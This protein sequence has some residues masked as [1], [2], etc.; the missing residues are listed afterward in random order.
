[1][2]KFKLLRIVLVIV[3]L[4]CAVLPAICE[5]AGDG[6]E[7]IETAENEINLF[8]VKQ[9]DFVI[10]SRGTHAYQDPYASAKAYG[11]FL[12]RSVVQ[13]MSIETDVNGETWYEVEYLSN[14][15]LESKE[16]YGGEAEDKDEPRIVYVRASE[17]YQRS[18][19]DERKIG[20]NV[21]VPEG[22]KPLCSP[23]A[24]FFHENL[25]LSNSVSAVESYKYRFDEEYAVSFTKRN[26]TVGTDVS[27]DDILLTQIGSSATDDGTQGKYHGDSK[28]IYAPKFEVQSGNDSALAYPLGHFYAKDIPFEDTILYKRIKMPNWSSGVQRGVAFILSHAPVFESYISWPGNYEEAS[29]TAAIHAL[30]AFLNDYAGYE[31][32]ED[33]FTGVEAYNNS[34]FNADYFGYMYW[35]YNGAARA[36]SD[37]ECKLE[38]E[39]IF[40]EAENSNYPKLVVLSEKA[41]SRDNTNQIEIGVEKAETHK[42]VAEQN[43]VGKIEIKV[44]D[45]ENGKALEGASYR[46]ERI[47]N[48]SKYEKDAKSG[49]NGVVAFSDVPSGIYYLCQNKSPKGYGGEGLNQII[50]IKPDDKLSYQIELS[51]LSGALKV[52][53]NDTLYNEPLSNVEFDININK[54]NILA[55]GKTDNKGE[56][57]IE[58]IPAG[59]YTIRAKSKEGY[60][61]NDKSYTIKINVGEI[62]IQEI[63]FEPVTTKM[64]IYTRDQEKVSVDR[65]RVSAPEAQG[66][67]KLEKAKFNLFAEE[68]ILTPNGNV[69]YESG[70]CV[71]EGIEPSGKSLMFEMTGLIPGKYR[72]VETS[73]PEGYYKAEDIIIDTTSAAKLIANNEEIIIAKH[74]V[75]SGKISLI[76]YK[77]AVVNGKGET[78]ESGA[79]FEI[80]LTSSGSYRKAPGEVC[81]RIITGKDGTGT[82]KSMPYGKYTITQTSGDKKTAL[83][84]PFEVL[85]DGSDTNGTPVIVIENDTP[86]YR[87]TIE[88]VDTDTK[89]R[90]PIEGSQ[91]IVKKN[92]GTKRILG[93]INKDGQLTVKEMLVPGKYTIEQSK[94]VE[95]YNPVKS[96]VSFELGSEN[97]ENGFV[98]QKTIA[99]ENSKKRIKLN[100]KIWGTVLSKFDSIEDENG[101]QT[102]PPVFVT[103]PMPNIVLEVYALSDIY[104]GNGAVAYKSGDLVTQVKTDQDGVAQTKPLYTGKYEIRAKTQMP[105]YDTDKVIQFNISENGHYNNETLYN[106]IIYNYLPVEITISQTQQITSSKINGDGTISQ[107]QDVIRAS[108]FVYG[109]YNK[110]PISTNEEDFPSDM[111]IVSAKTGADGRISI[112]GLLPHNEYY[113]RMISAPDGY[114]LELND[115]PISLTNKDNGFTVTID[116]LATSKI[117]GSTVQVRILDVDTRR[118]LPDVEVEIRN[119]KNVVV[120]RGNT[121]LNGYLPKLI[122][123]AGTYRYKDTLAIEGYAVSENFSSFTISDGGDVIGSLELGVSQTT[124][125]INIRD[126]HNN[127]LSGAVYGLYSKN[128]RLI[129]TSTSDNSGMIVFKGFGYGEYEIRPMQTLPGYTLASREIIL[130]VDGG[131]KNPEVPIVTL[132]AK[133]I[134][135]AGQVQ[136]LEGNPI[137]GAVIA[138]NASG[139]TTFQTTKSDK[140]GRYSF[141]GIPDGSYQL[142]QKEGT[143]SYLRSLKTYDVSINSFTGHVT[144]IETFINQKREISFR[145]TNIKNEPV[146]EARFE[147]I[148]KNN[149]KIVQTESSDENGLVLFDQF[150]YGDYLIRNT[151]MP[152]DYLLI[153]D[154]NYEIDESWNYL[155]KEEI[156]A[157]YNYCSVRIVDNYDNAIEG[158]TVIASRDGIK[159]M[160][161]RSNENGYARIN[162]LDKGNYDIIILSLPDNYRT[163]SDKISLRI[164][165]EYVPEDKTIVVEK[166]DPDVIEQIRKADIH[167]I[168][169]TSIII[170]SGALLCVIAAGVVI[171]VRNRR[172]KQ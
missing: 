136:D 115:I 34:A 133:A 41:E 12:D 166:L 160:E 118:G 85:I 88:N 147:M 42:V 47:D 43:G 163:E 154:I 15:T 63:L 165:D 81:Y 171:G 53:V 146:S 37:K 24:S 68:N 106:E 107:K 17:I 144:N 137:Q 159:R 32:W 95:G 113:L 105:D 16:I 131:Y 49:K 128:G 142:L 10:V 150:D 26:R 52:V 60:N 108:G 4:V 125:T 172:K 129:Q 145:I 169:Q 111:L 90:I 71:A 55:S 167:N 76:K 78:P 143:E 168:S 67:A 19:Y 54:W 8:H 2:K 100:V 65:K 30:W 99:V 112:R 120:Y 149:N 134:E 59:E 86:L 79:K 109:L 126:E 36:Y 33:I 25:L 97:K 50:E 122:L 7:V 98:Y 83:K 87:L 64:S 141:D 1:M 92:D 158:V 38:W 152:D 151:S 84:T 77:D 116:N 9:S 93:T 11:Y 5:E 74:E 102:R 18:L 156:K 148:D 22:I 51:K 35:L 130:N 31:E 39:M 124:A 135:I 91:Y 70:K 94:S 132:Y 13:V 103:A 138:L 21:I 57:L 3:V 110:N 45:K 170:A 139:G 127:P 29:R 153:S 162:G 101:Q 58:N 119:A 28:F 117:A 96:A 73:T 48:I 66:D 20:A 123:P 72:L 89:Q 69:Y 80:Y 61:I 164:D 44:Q 155:G 14:P 62:A 27:Y 157:V 6:K 114:E 104:F 161:T 82:T 46:L 56:C 40:F 23:Y 75:K 121:E 140:Y